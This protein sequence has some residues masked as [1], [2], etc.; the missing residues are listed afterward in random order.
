MFLFTYACESLFSVMNFV[1]SSN[2]SSPM[3]ETSSTCI[4]IKVTKYKLDIKFVSSDA[5]AEFPLITYKK[6][7]QV[8]CL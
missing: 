2:S 7:Q 5:A 4:S 6:S 3:D 1:K 8:F